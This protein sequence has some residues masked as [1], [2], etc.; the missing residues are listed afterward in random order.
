MSVAF[1]PKSMHY[2]LLTFHNLYLKHIKYRIQNAQ[3]RRSEEKYNSIFVTYK[4]TVQSHGFH[5]YNNA[6][7]MSTATISPCT[8]KHHGLL[9]CKCVLRCCDKCPSIV[10]P[11]KV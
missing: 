6:V 4:N 3:N 7:D 2:Y 11:S 5:I 1:M 10:L 8:Y 9:H